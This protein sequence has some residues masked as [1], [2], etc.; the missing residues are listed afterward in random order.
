MVDEAGY[1]LS[2]LKKKTSDHPELGIGKDSVSLYRIFLPH[3][4]GLPL[5]P[6]LRQDIND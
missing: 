1:K 6:M 5:H 4:S 3:L 2:F